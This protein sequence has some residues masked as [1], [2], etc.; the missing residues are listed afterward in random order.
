MSQIE[1][2]TRLSEILAEL[3]RSP[4][5]GHFFQTLGDQAWAAVPC[6]Y[7]AVCLQDPEKGGYV[8]HSQV[9]LEEGAISRRVFAPDEGLP[10]RTISIGKAYVVE[11]LADE[12]G[13]P[14]LEGVLAA[15]GLRAA[16][17]V[18]IR[19]GLDVLGALL[20]AGRPPI[21]YGDDDLQIAQL[22]ASGLSSA[23]ETSRAYD[24][25]G[26]ERM[27][28]LAVLA[29]T[30]DAVIATNPAGV[31]LLANAAVRSMLGLAPDAIEAD[32]WPRP[33]T[34]PRCSSSSW[35]G[36][37]G[38]TSCRYLTDGPPRR[39][40]CRSAPRLASRLVWPR[41]FAISPCSRT[42]SR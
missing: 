3:F 25:L 21:V 29:S 36:G 6:D 42:S 37:R 4:I 8:V 32:R 9:E 14:D 24:K 12:D 16:L 10:G 15:A 30:G 39:A 22:M 20:F 31:V 19:S 26:G 27:T 7:L 41:S 40:S 5:P 28:M 35:P 1:R 38:S 13:A 23:L 18:P 33:S 2:L 17:V 34:I 11:D